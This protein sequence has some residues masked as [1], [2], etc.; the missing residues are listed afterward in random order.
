MKVLITIG[1][2]TIEK[3]M[4]V[5]DV[6]ELGLTTSSNEYEPIISE[7]N[8]LI[9]KKA[10]LIKRIKSWAIKNNNYEKTHVLFVNGWYIAMKNNG[11]FSKKYSVTVASYSTAPFGD[12][13]FTSEKTAKEALEI[14]GNEIEDIFSKEV[15]LEA[16]IG[17]KPNI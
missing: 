9:D 1:D 10:E 8:D 2:K 16:S 12:V 15:A 6:N 13:Y 7:I 3:E 14:F 5:Q 4:S 17:A 11:S